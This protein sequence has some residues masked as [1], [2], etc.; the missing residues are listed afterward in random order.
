VNIGKIKIDGKIVLAPLAGYTNS[1]Y[2]MI[3]K[4]AGANLV[5]SEMI[6]AKGLIFEND[7]TFDLTY[8]DPNEHPIAMQIFGG[9]VEDLVRA[10]KILDKNTECD[11]ID[12][13]MG[14]PVRKVYRFSYNILIKLKAL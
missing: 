9:E 4:K 2:R 3:C 1:V 5:Y 7:K 10:A 14:C 12:I 13:N 6:S 11:I 8:V